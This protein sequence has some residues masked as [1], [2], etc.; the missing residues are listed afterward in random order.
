[1]LHLLE[2]NANLTYLMTLHIM[3]QPVISDN[4]INWKS[5]VI[6]TNNGHPSDM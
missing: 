3:V 5:N 4:N 2:F 1:M 6:N